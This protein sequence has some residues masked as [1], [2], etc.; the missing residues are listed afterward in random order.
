MLL[1]HCQIAQATHVS[2]SEQTYP[3]E[4]D[5]IATILFVG[6]NTLSCARVSSSSSQLFT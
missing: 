3:V 4:R 2:W 6:E 1:E 5:V